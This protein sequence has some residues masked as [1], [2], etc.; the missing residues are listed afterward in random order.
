[1]SPQQ[2]SPAAPPT[3]GSAGPV[4]LEAI[5]ANV[6]TCIARTELAG[7]HAERAA[8]AAERSERLIGDIKRAVQRQAS[9][10]AWLRHGI[11]ASWVGRFAMVGAAAVIG[12]VS[13]IVVVAC[14]VG[15]P[16]H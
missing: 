3:P 14:S 11:P 4:T 12:A 13:A 1:V 7:K 15:M 9:D 5:A 6:Q 2:P 16:P 10:Y 8:D